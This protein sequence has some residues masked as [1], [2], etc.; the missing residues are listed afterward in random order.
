MVKKSLG[1]IIGGWAFLVGVIIAIIVGFIGTPSS[2]ILTTLVIIG[3]LIG[4]FN[5]ADKEASSFLIS[6]VVLVIVGALG[7]NA[8]G[9]LTIITGIL[10]ALMAIFVPATIIVAI[11]N[12]L[13]I[14]RD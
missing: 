12:V 13:S 14:A 2:A 9:S 4:L 3:I 10:S 6:G 5:I 8:F 1:D 11:K 7:G